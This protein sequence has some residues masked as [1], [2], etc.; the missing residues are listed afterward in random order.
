MAL[1][2]VGFGTYPLGAVPITAS[3]GNVANAAAVATLAAVAG[4]RTY[5]TG[6]IITSTGA[7]AG[8]AVSPTVTGTVSGT[9]TFAMAAAAGTLAANT[10]LSFNFIFPVPANADNTAIVITLPA[11]GIGNTNATVV[12]TGYQL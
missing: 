10:P 9:M 11:L 5:M 6:L 12:A 4:K 8:L 2:P 3:S 1:E 7:T